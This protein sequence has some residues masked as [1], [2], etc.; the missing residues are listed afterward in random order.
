LNE[1]ARYRV[2][3]IAGIGT[4]I[5]VKLLQSLSIEDRPDRARF[6]RPDDF[7]RASAPRA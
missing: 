4:T 7:I 3:E 6:P 1:T 5:A 2:P